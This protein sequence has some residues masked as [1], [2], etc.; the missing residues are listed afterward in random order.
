MKYLKYFE[1]NINPFDEEWEDVEDVDMNMVP[2]LND[3]FKIYVKNKIKEGIKSKRM[4]IDY[5]NGIGK[6]R[7][8]NDFKSVIT[9]MFDIPEYETYYF[10]NIIFLIINTYRRANEGKSILSP[11]QIKGFMIYLFK[12]YIPLKSK[13]KFIVRLST[14]LKRNKIGGVELTSPFPINIDEL[15][16]IVSDCG[17]WDHLKQN[18]V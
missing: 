15:N 4:I 5:F 2:P 7:S 16:K 13:M 1:N 6:F 8:F 10:D 11:E 18:A 17:G 14:I 9:T 12:T 3:K